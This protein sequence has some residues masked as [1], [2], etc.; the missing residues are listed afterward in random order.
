MGHIKFI[1]SSSLTLIIFTIFVVMY[2]YTLI[3]NSNNTLLMFKPI[4]LTLLIVNVIVY[5][6]LYGIHIYALMILF[7]FLFCLIGDISLMFSSNVNLLIGGLSF[8][9]AR[10]V[11]SLAH[12]SYSEKNTGIIFSHKVIN[13]KKILLMIIATLILVT[14]ESIFFSLY[15]KSSITGK[16]LVCVY[17]VSMGINLFTVCNRL[18]FDEEMLMCKLL[19]FIGTLLFIVSD[20]MLLVTMFDTVYPYANVISITI[21][22]VSMFLIMLSVVRN[23]NYE[24]E[25]Y[26][27]DV[28]LFLN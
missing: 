11:F 8:F 13:K 9:I 7:A 10:L 4:P 2:D 1:I 21:Y 5:F 19:S 22:W 17:I 3:T 26:M 14:L 27:K 18:D 25:K 15:M 12:V 24:T 16:I 23:R 20:I 6:I 28:Y